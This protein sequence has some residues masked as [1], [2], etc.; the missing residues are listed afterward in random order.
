MILVNQL[1]PLESH[2]PFANRTD[3]GNSFPIDE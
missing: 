2:W 3:F 1:G